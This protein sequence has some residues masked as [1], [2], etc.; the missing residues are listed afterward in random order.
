METGR[1]QSITEYASRTCISV[2]DDGTQYP[3]TYFKIGDRKLCK[4]LKSQGEPASFSCESE[5]VSKLAAVQSMFPKPTKYAKPASFGAAKR[6]G[7]KSQSKFMKPQ[8]IK[9]ATREELNAMLGL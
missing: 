2:F 5:A 9:K 8:V 3:S 6:R 4:Y 1:V 7:Q